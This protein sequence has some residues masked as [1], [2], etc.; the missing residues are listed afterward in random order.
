MRKVYYYFMS[1][2]KAKRNWKIYHRYR[3]KDGLSYGNI[4]KII[5]AEQGQKIHK[6]TVYEICKREEAR[7]VDKVGKRKNI[8]LEKAIA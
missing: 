6:Q 8:A 2:E 1:V 7:A 3:L 4:A 5:T